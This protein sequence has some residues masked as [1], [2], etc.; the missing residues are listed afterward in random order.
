MFLGLDSADRDQEPQL[1]HLLGASPWSPLWTDSEKRS[2]LL[3]QPPAY[4]PDHHLWGFRSMA[5]HRAKV[6]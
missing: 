6:W 1:S 3:H 4:L 2:F 5:K